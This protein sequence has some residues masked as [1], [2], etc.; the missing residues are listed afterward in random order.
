ML[1]V[2]KNMNCPA[3]W[4]V[5]K[6]PVL[7]WYCQSELLTIKERP[8]R[9]FLQSK[10]IKRS[11]LLLLLESYLPYEIYVVFTTTLNTSS[12]KARRVVDTNANL[13]RRYLDK[14][15]MNQ[16]EDLEKVV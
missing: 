12:R 6:L 1:A 7:V 16:V 4:E 9:C 11:L 5:S 13:Q 15:D 14:E 8:L 3:L 2:H 10:S